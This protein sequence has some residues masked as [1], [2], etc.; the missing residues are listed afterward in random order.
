M[1]VVAAV[2]EEE[3]EEI[4]EMPEPPPLADERERYIDQL[5]GELEA[6]QQRLAREEDVRASLEQRLHLTEERVREQ[7]AMVERLK[8]EV[9]TNLSTITALTGMVEEAQAV[10]GGK[11][12]KNKTLEEKFLK[13]KE[14]YLVQM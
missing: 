11:E 13:L 3:A 1:A 2:P 14:V 12:D 5:I 10:Q 7:E 4:V 6:A 9:E 8:A